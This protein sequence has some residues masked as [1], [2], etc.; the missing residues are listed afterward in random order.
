MMTTRHARRML[1]AALVLAAAGCSSRSGGHAGLAGEAGGPVRIAPSPATV[2]TQLAAVVDVPSVSPAQ[3]AF[4]WTCN[5]EVVAGATGAVLDPSHFRKGDFVALAVTLPAR[6]GEVARTMHARVRIAD[7][8]PV[9][10]SARLMADA[11]TGGADLQATAEG[12]DPDGDA[13][14]YT[15]RW[16]RNGTPIENAADSRLPVGSLGRGDRVAVEVTASDGETNSQPLRSDDFV[17]DN[18]APR[19]A[20]A[21]ASVPAGE[22]AF[23]FQAKAVDPDGDT[24]HYDLSQA[25]A[26]MTISADGTIDWPLP[27][28]EGRQAEYSVTIRA[29]DSRGGQATQQFT[30]RLT[31]QQVAKS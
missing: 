9:V 19:F 2:K 21:P 5:G 8:P 18:R 24:V 22:N 23:R 11:E 26:G 3:C 29:T 30:I 14:T 17:L 25:P 31:T 7:A 13:T 28:K 16:Y 27:P 6:E 4:A 1:A 10:Q 15:Y 20:S 12:M